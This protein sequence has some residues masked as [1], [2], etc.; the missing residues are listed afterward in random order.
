VKATP[1]IKRI[2]RKWWS[3]P[4]CFAFLFLIGTTRAEETT[5][6]ILHYFGVQD[7]QQ[8][9]NQ[10]VTAFQ[11]SNPDIK[12]RL[13]LVPFGELLSRTLQTAAVCQPPAIVALDNPDVLRA[14]KAGV[15][16][17]IFPSL[18]QFPDW[19][20]IYDAVKRVISDGD[21]VYGI[22]IGSNSIAFGLWNRANSGSQIR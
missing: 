21:H 8:A 7:Q 2:N 11:H 3:L 1:C 18:P 14:A 15:L 16:E 4:I 20:N 13:T 6:E 9:L 5:I 17:D 22:P 10:V 12:I 19:K